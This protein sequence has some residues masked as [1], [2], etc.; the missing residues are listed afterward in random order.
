ML[1][2]FVYKNGQGNFW[3]A[4]AHDH[5]H[6]Y[7]GFDDQWVGEDGETRVPT[8]V[9]GGEDSRSRELADLNHI[10]FVSHPDNYAEF[11]LLTF[12]KTDLCFWQVTG[13][14]TAASPDLHA[15]AAQMNRRGKLYQEYFAPSQVDTN[16]KG[17][18]TELPPF[19]V[20]PVKLIATVPRHAIYTSVDSL[21]SYQYL[22]RGTCRPLW[23]ASGTNTDDMPDEIVNHVQKS[24]PR[25]KLIK[26]ER[27]FA[28]FVRL[29][30]NELLHRHAEVQPQL[31]RPRLG[32]HATDHA[33]ALRI[34][35]A[36]LNPILVETAALAFVQDLGLTPDIGV[37]KTKD[38]VDIR[39]RAAGADGGI[40]K[41]VAEVA[42]AKLKGL[43]IVLSPGLRKNLVKFGVL[44]IQC[45]AA[46]QKGGGNGVLYFGF[47]DEKKTAED[48]F[49][50]NVVDTLL[51][52][53]DWPHLERFFA[54]QARILRGDW[55]TQP[56]A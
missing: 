30:L 6:L 21:A 40:D 43:R 34:V 51:R 15:A 33:S 17:T 7:V 1:N 14:V 23:R 38:V 4:L 44:D 24:I 25:C 22:I 54:M 50:L 27:P 47:K 2:Y 11:L 18:N 10:L 56:V 26:P 12:E 49:R 32:N 13:P 42:L 5:G 48:V 3:S 31:E 9:N 39:A 45:K 41:G 35:K 36:T 29:Y 20:L 28:A 16:T 19:R 46:D 8:S 37:G 53:G 52:A 55:P